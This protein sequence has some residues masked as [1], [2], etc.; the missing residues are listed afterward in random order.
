MLLLVK[1]EAM[2]GTEREIAAPFTSDNL[3][4]SLDACS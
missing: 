4:S 1:F 2:N 3:M